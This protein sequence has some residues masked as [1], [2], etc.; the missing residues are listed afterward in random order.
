MVTAAWLFA[1]GLLR[2]R[3]VSWIGGLLGA[4]PATVWWILAALFVAWLYGNHRERAGFAQCTVQVQQATQKERDR[5]Q[6]ELARTRSEVDQ[7]LAAAERQTQ[8]LNQKVEAANE[9]VRK[10]KD[11][12]AVCL[13]GSVTDKLRNIRR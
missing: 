12:S 10:L 8:E 13:P 4:I 3:A 11:R 9:E 2:H 7:Q 1:V 6:K 5:W